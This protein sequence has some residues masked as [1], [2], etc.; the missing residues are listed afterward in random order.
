MGRQNGVKMKA[1]RGASG[2]SCEQERQTREP[3][4]RSKALNENDIPSVS[5]LG[6]LE[7]SSYFNGRKADFTRK[8]GKP[9]MT[10]KCSAPL[11]TPAVLSRGRLLHAFRV[12][13]EAQ[14]GTEQREPSPKGGTPAFTF[15]WCP[16]N[17]RSLELGGILQFTQSCLGGA[18]DPH[19]EVKTNVDSCYNTALL[20]GAAQQSEV[21]PSYSQHQRTFQILPLLTFRGLCLSEKRVG[22]NLCLY[23]W[24]LTDR[25]GETWGKYQKGCFLFLPWGHAF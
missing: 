7:Q 5:P 19:G 14:T 4:R 12:F 17:R 10:T 20:S 22:W 13:F 8:R 6:E 15:S 21:E 3:E 23:H 11:F 1:P 16:R 9:T 2:L 24:N 25:Q 18:V